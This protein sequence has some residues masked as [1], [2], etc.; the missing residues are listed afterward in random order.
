MIV[1]FQYF[2]AAFVLLGQYF[3]TEP[4]TIIKSFIFSAIGSLSL[5]IYTILTSQYGFVVL[6]IVAI[7]LAVKGFI[8]WRVA[9]KEVR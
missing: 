7:V 4:N 6:N 3:R 5:L 1:L 8:R 9:M 2:G